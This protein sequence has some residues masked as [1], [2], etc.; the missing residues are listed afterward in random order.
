VSIETARA[1]L[2]CSAFTGISRNH[3][4]RLVEELATP[5]A[6]A[7]EVRLYR[8]RGNQQRR[9]WPGADHPPPLTFR[10]RLLCTLVWLRLGGSGGLT[11]PHPDCLTWPLRLR[12]G[13]DGE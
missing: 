8:R 10:D 7:R 3:L 5:F 6:A 12:A 4:D 1:A 9:R 2:S 11:W 13:D